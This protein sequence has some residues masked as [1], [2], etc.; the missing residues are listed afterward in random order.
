MY[1]AGWVLINVLIGMGCVSVADH[2]DRDGGKWFIIG[3]L[4]GVI[5][6]IVLAVLPALESED[7]PE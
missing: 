3:L 2:K 4:G 7:N 1:F 5:A 6:L